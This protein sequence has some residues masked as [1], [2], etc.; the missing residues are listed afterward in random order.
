[1]GVPKFAAWLTKK[2]PAMVVDRCPADVHGLYIDLNGLIHPCCHDEHDA[3]VALRTEVEKMRSVCLAIETL[4]VTVKPQR[5]LYIAIDGVA[6]RAKMNQQRARRYMS[7]ATPLTNTEKPICSSGG[8][9]IS[10]AVVAATEA[11][12]TAA[13]RT[14]AEKELEDV[15]QALLGD[16]LYGGDGDPTAP[17]AAADCAFSPVAPLQEATAQP[18]IGVPFAAVGAAEDYDER[19]DSNCISPGTAFMDK[20]AATVR[21]FVKRKLMTAETKADSGDVTEGC[22]D[23]PLTWASG[24]STATTA[25][26]AAPSAPSPWAQLTVVFS[27]SNTAGEGEHKF[28]DFLRTQSAFPGFNGSGCH[29]IAGLDADLIFLSL[30]LHIPR[31]VILRDHDR[32][33]Y[34]RAL[35]PVAA[36]GTLMP[37][38]TAAKGRAAGGVPESDSTSS[39]GSAAA[40]AAA[41]GTPAAEVDEASSTPQ[42]SEA[43]VATPSSRR[44]EGDDDGAVRTATMSTA[45]DV[46]DAEKEGTVASPT[47]DSPPA[48]PVPPPH[49]A[50]VVADVCTSYEYY[51]IDVVGASIVSEVYQLCLE[52]GMEMRGNPLEN[53]ANCVAANGFAF[54]RS[55]DSERSEAAAVATA[56]AAAPTPTTQ[57][58]A[59]SNK[60]KPSKSTAPAPASSPHSTSP[61]SF[62]PCTSTS[63]SK[64]IDDFIVLGMLLGN[65]F[66]PHSPS[67][68]CGE[69]A[70]D[71]LMD[72]YVSAVLP[73]GYLTGG[74]YE[75]QLLQL[76]RLLRAY[77]TVEAVRFRQ[78][79]IQSGLM[80][81]QEAATSAVYSEADRRCWRDPYIRTTSL[82]NE[83]GVQAACRAYVEGLRFVWRY[84]SSI[85]LQVSWSW[86][87]PFHHAPL[88]LDVANFLRQQ[89]PNVQAVLAAPKLER[90]PPPPFCQLLCI[91]PPPSRT[92][93][94]AALRASMV[95]PP[96]ELADTFPTTW[97]VD[98]TGAYGKE[99]LAAVL[100]PFANL[101]DLQALVQTHAGSYTAEERARNT[102]RSTH[103]V[104]EGRSDADPIA[105]EEATAAAADEE[106]T[107]EAPKEGSG[108]GKPKRG[109]AV[110]KARG[111]RIQG[112]GLRPLAAAEVPPE[113]QGCSLIVCSSLADV[114]PPPSRPR[115]YSYT[116]L[117]PNLTLLPDGTRMPAERRPQSRYGN[118]RRHGGR[119]K[120]EKSTQG[121]TLAAASS[122]A[123]SAAAT[124]NA[125]ARQPPM[126][127]GEFII[128]LA[129]VGLL[130]AIVL[131]RRSSSF[132]GGLQLV[133]Q[134][135][136]VAVTV[137]GVA[138]ALGLAVAGN[139]RAAGSGMHRHNIFTAFA[140]WQCASCLSL[141]FSRN[142]RCFICRA[143][144]DPH[145]CAALLSGRNPPE[146]PLM[147]PDHTA[148]SASYGITPL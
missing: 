89:G 14:G 93:V 6:P 97:T 104:F 48:S 61:R 133:V 29:V 7:A 128:S 123:S 86:Y 84:Y 116:V 35:L 120:D 101:P 76:E 135:C 99:H 15:R 43:V 94:P 17:S 114:A 115:T 95:Q 109:S 33:S 127:F 75:I 66:L 119:G 148:Y 69:S 142:R 45:E 65:D 85:S 118:R 132:L 107:T 74:H 18:E 72:V 51:D 9:E 64:I 129:V 92:L 103:I 73:Y 59:P 58:R 16:V 140:D 44:E 56:P 50:S 53:S 21:D 143:P 27:D 26:T 49:I 36:G 96:A 146:V 106:H 144:F 34:D 113:L 38:K 91:L 79:A 117:I 4:V 8:H 102:L 77:A 55:G 12:F 23:D 40:A 5:V 30:S 100:L 131:V 122:S 22:G 13:E 83:A 87:Y 82:T 130:S 25:A 42:P 11:E 88:A 145:R 90:L 54:Y 147:D 81:P 10:A 39:I 41:V 108:R 78:H 46:T 28:V 141:N 121:A 105:A 68:Y 70:M 110:T 139:G 37:A 98:F 20:V 124:A 24:T 57:K 112:D 125:H 80:T 126:L 71:T 60:R 111:F 134:M 2:Y 63:N 137:L 52:K 19:F 31:V 1:M 138:F 47:P 32:S 67:V 3:T 136:A 62:H